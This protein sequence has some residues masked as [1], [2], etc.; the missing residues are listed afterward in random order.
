M[1]ATAGAAS[2]ADR[3]EVKSEEARVRVLAIIALL[4]ALLL[5]GAGFLAERDYAPLNWSLLLWIAL[6]IVADMFPIPAGKNLW[7]GLDLPLLLGM[8]LIYGPAVTG[9]AALVGSVSFAEIRGEVPF[10]RALYNHA[11][12]SMSV[13]AAG[14][15]FRVAGGHLGA[16]PAA[17]FAGLLALS[18]DGV[19]NYSLV[20]LIRSN[21]THQ[22]FAR[23]LAE[24]RFGSY[25]TFLPA[26]ACFGLGGVLV[27]ELFNAVGPWGLAAFVVPVLLARQA[28]LHH[29]TV[30]STI[31]ALDARNQQLR[32]VD[33]RISAERQ[34]ERMRIAEALH[35]DVLQS[36]HGVCIRSHVLREDLRSGRL[37]DLDD[38]LPALVEVTE[39]ALEEVRGVIRGLRR[40][41]LG[42]SGL[43]DTL[44]LLAR[45]IQDEFGVKVLLELHATAVESTAQLLLYQIAREAL[46]N[47]ARH[48][49]ADVVRVELLDNARGI[50]MTVEDYGHGFDLDRPVAGHHFGLE[51][52]RERA[53]TVGG[54]L[55][56]R[57]SPDSGTRIRVEIPMRD[58]RTQR[59]R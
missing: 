30:E 8:A 4:V 36:L 27:A 39:R 19:I 21:A 53:V 51:L 35:D 31:A 48:S 22:S 44:Q 11:Q 25:R 57:S 55:E 50:T 7:F 3:V 41:P 47:A 17:G 46:F 56:I 9:L 45:H 13:F 23:A 2:N 5:V 34:D 54:E 1:S 43:L 28:F 24:L 59:P 16:W 33:E 14:T 49:G 6:V 40:S 52:M 37:L 38:D 20:A 58:E 10:W 18:A 26:Y 15:V 29:Q 42:R 32:R 12:V